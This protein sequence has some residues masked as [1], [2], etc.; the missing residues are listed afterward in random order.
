MIGGKLSPT[1]AP[2][3]IGPVHW[4]FVIPVQNVA[5]ARN[6]LFLHG[7]ETGTTN[8]PDLAYASGIELPNARALKERHLFVP[9]HPHLR[10]E[11][12][13]RVFNILRKAG[14]I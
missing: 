13:A 8:L 2:S 11:D 4:Q 5:E 14:Q 3:H 12:Y 6:V 10:Y 1:P 9:M 7:I